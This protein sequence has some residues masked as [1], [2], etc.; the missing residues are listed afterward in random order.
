MDRVV[1][2]GLEFLTSLVESRKREGTGSPL[3]CYF[4]QVI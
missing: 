3:Q 1:G 2:R 4:T